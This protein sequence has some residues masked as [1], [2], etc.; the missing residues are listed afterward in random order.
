MNLNKP[1]EPPRC[2][3]CGVL[4]DRPREL[5]TR[6]L[7][8]FP[9][10]S[11][12]C[13]AVYACDV[14]GH[15]IGAAM[16]EALVFACNGDWD[17]A[18]QLSS[19]DDYLDARIEHYDDITHQ[20]V[21]GGS[22]EGRRAWGVLLFIKLHEEIKEVTQPGVEA[23][24]SRATPIPTP[25]VRRSK[26]FS[27]KE[28]QRLAKE[29]R[30][31]EL[32]DMA[33]QDTRAIMVLHRLLYSADEEV[34]WQAVEMLG[35]VAAGVADTKP[36]SISDLLR[37]LLYSSTDSAAS[38]W[39]A[40]EAVAEIISNRPDMFGGFTP[41]LLSFLED[42]TSR[43][44][45]LWGVGRIGKTRPDLI[46][47]AIPLLLSFLNDPK[48][49]IRGHAAWALG[50]VR[51]VETKE[52]LKKLKNDHHVITIYENEKIQRKTVGYLAKEAIEKI[53]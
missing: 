37:R 13:G 29:K 4:I 19:G 45:V 39:G 51:V 36:R 23:E 26:S 24:L 28:V 2:P 42:E 41:P 17:L 9:L 35:R 49:S 11:C 22:L 15:N 12:K 3:F 33:E 31:L 10:G 50:M 5:K 6:R 47:K 53:G 21:P 27:K 14:T 32:V 1:A 30:V 16:I 8:E 52:K 40:L 20:V 38:S 46:R 7:S 25:K 18:W 48:P 34:R 44:G 43:I